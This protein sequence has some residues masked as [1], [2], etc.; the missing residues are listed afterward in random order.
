MGKCVEV[1][2]QRRRLAISRLFAFSALAVFLHSIAGFA[3]ETSQ[4]LAA[5]GEASQQAAQPP[6]A[7]QSSDQTLMDGLFFGQTAPLLNGSEYPG[8]ANLHISGFLQNTT[9]VWADSEAITYNSSK[10]S[11][12]IERNLLQLDINYDLNQSNKF[13]LRFWGVYEPPYPFESGRQS[14][15]ILNGPA[16]NASAAHDFYNQ[17]VIREVWWKNILGPLTTFTGR[18]IVVWGESVSFRVGDVINPQDLSWNF[19]FANLEQS[20]LPL[21]MIHPIL[22]LP[23]AGP[24]SANFIEGVFAP[25]WQPLYANVG[26]PDARNQ[27]HYDVAGSVSILAPFGARFDRRPYPIQFPIQAITHHLPPSAAAFPQFTQICPTCPPPS[28]SRWKLPADTLENSEEGFRLHSVVGNGELAAF[29]WHAHQSGPA[30]FVRGGGNV[31]NFLLCGYPGYNDIGITANHP[32]YLPDISS[33]LPFVI[34][35]EG[36]WQDRTPFR[37]QS[38]K[39]P[40]GVIFSSTLNTMLALD[41]DQVYTPSI[42]QTGALTANLEWQNYTIL[43]PSGDLVYQGYAEKWRHNEENVLLNIGTSWWWGA[44]A[45]TWTSIYNPDGNTFLLFPNLVLTPPW[46][47]RYL[48]K[49][50]YVGVLGTDKY[51]AFAGGAFKG[52]SILLTQFQYNFDLL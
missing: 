25:A 22:N 21:W 12:A 47:D 43:S 14:N 11:L 46:T 52:K 51:A 35:A 41:L 10:S 20:R 49:L 24:A 29:Y 26:Y 6:P 1:I 7:Q 18:Q 34:R 45:P 13:F 9:G 4:P 33:E 40:T 17:Y 2:S 44:I 50:E 39:V 15:A 5:S 8:L 16:E 42:T 36:V 30:G 27:G 37:T 3:A 31:Y 48:M 28:N 32:L 19:G 38:S 23:D